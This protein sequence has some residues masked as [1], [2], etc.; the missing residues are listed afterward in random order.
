MQ[1]NPDTLVSLLLD[2]AERDPA[3]VYM[4]DTDGSEVTY[5]ETV[6]EARRWGAAWA[7][8]GVGPGDFVVTMRLNAGESVF[9]WLGLSA[10]DAVEAPINIDYRG[11]LL[12]H[13]L[14]LTRARVIAVSAQYVPRLLDVASELTHVEKVVL[15]DSDD[16]WDLPWSVVTRRGFLEGLEPL[17]TLPPP[18][19]WAIAVVLFTSGTT[20]PSKAVLIPWGQIHAGVTGMIP[21]QDLGEDE[22]IFN[23]GPTYHLGSRVMPYLAALVGGRHVVR[24]FISRSELADV[25]ERYGVTMGSTLMPPEWV[26][27][28]ESLDDAKRPI[29]NML[30]PIKVPGWERLKE[31]FGFRSFGCFAMT[32]ISVPICDVDWDSAKYDSEGRMSCGRLRVGYPWC[33]ARVVD[34]HDQPVPHGQVGELIV[35]ASAPWVMN[36]GYLNMPEATAA[37]WRNGWFHT[38][39]GFI[40]DD[41]GYFYFID[42]LKD[43]IR[44]HGENIS[45]AEVE[46]HV[47]EHPAVLECAAIAIKQANQ[48]GADEEVKVVVVRETDRVVSPDELVKW[49]VPRMPRFMI[50]RYVEF[51]DELPRTP[52]L[53]VRKAELRELGVTAA[54]WDREAAGIELPRL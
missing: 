40:C 28:P 11:S 24:P 14:E 48:P 23:A 13:A 1:T 53:K 9:A 16:A 15:L 49:L 18:P 2:R 47:T 35:R 33:E 51:V 34:E 38:G 3:R 17:P 8:L 36:A 10:L 4:I 22:V 45:S 37:A 29:R 46:A 44:R 54:T 50:P 31:R 7:R 25:Y 52:T 5:G 32:E 41:E 39:D 26:A 27:A 19:P 20:G 12:V 30:A 21:T 42:R 43:C 6:D